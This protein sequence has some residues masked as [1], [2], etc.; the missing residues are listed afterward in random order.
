MKAPEMTIDM[1]PRTVITRIDTGEIVE[2]ADVELEVEPATVEEVSAPEAEPLVLEEVHVE[3]V[4]ITVPESNEHGNEISRA[5]M[6]RN[7]ATIMIQNTPTL[8]KENVEAAK[9][10]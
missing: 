8:T 3:P 10:L 2:P 1:L 4:E 7:V 9:E 5:E 6:L